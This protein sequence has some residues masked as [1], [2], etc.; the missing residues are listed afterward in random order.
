M[1]S[2]QQS[3]SNASFK[4]GLNKNVV[5]LQHVFDCK[6][7]E[8]YLKKQGIHSDFLHNKPLALAT[9]IAVDILNKL[10]S[11]FSLFPFWSPS[12]NVYNRQDLLLGPDLYHFCIPEP[13][14]VLVNKPMYDKTSIFYSNIQSLERLDD[15]AEQ[16]YKS[17]MKP[18]NHFLAD[19][20][21]EMMHAIFVKRIYDKYQNGALNVLNDLQ[22]KHF[23]NNE[24]EIIGNILGIEA[25]Q[26]LNQYHE[27]FANTFTKIICSSLNKN[28][29]TINN[30][31]LELFK[32]YPRNF[33][34][35]I[36]KILDV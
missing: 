22:Y 20:I 35:I 36:K 18:S 28:N 8:N 13:K 11:T 33:I 32:N 26:P 21:H 24:N 34:E 23:E 30:N 29:L 19:I 31:P 6:Y 4:A 5:R 16:A 14:K 10:H 25:M 3:K 9:N 2:I 17:G 15:Y 12:I 27:V 7:A 1:L